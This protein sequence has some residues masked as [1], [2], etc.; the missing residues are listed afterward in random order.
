M[1]I[2]NI[3]LRN[4]RKFESLTVKLDPQMNVIAG[5]NGV[6]KSSVLDALSVGIGSFFLGIDK[7]PTPKIKTTDVRYKT[8][9]IGSRI[10]RQPQYPVAI[11]CEGNV[12]GNDISWKRSLNTE[13]GSTTS[14]DASKIKKISDD[15]KDRV[16]KGD[17]QIILPIISYYGTGRLWSQK[18]E[19]QGSGELNL[20]NRFYGYTDCLSASSNE[21]LMIKWFRSMTL[22][23]LQEQ[24]E[25]PKLSAVENAIAECF[26]D[27][28]LTADKVK[29]RFSVKTDEIEISYL[30]ENGES[31]QHPFHELSDGFRNTLSMVADIAYRMAVLNPHL[32]D[33]VTKKTP[34]VVLIDEIDQHLHPRWQK[35]ILRSL[36]KIFPKVQFIV[37]T[38]SP[39]VISS[40][41]RS[42]LILFD[43]EKCSYIDDS[44]G[45]DSNSV[46]VE[47][48]GVSLRPEDVQKKLDRFYETLDDE[49][50]DKAKEI[51]GQLTEMLGEG[52]GDVV[53]A[54]VALDFETC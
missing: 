10:D 30:N 45:K 15:I 43:N 51:L 18:K 48:M 20:S 33:D 13:S 27:S 32:L 17:Q 31:E 22:H 19:K 44:Y 7:V 5:N 38:H 14:V 53:S 34:G 24:I 40:A 23:R 2:Q 9:Q 49:E 35:N 29:V 6:G 1:K 26:V 39:I 42:Q 46:L 3:E 52:N 36:M 47:I 28:G 4:F 25:I 41:V 50:F 54:K 11:E 21:K 8:Y 16:R 37:T 12:D